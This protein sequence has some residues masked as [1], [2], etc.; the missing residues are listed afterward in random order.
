VFHIE[1]LTKMLRAIK[2]QDAAFACSFIE[3]ID[4][5]GNVTGIKRGW[6]SHLPSW[7]LKTAVQDS[8]SPQSFARNLLVSNFIST[9]S[10]MLFQRNVL[11]KVGGFRNLRFSH[12]WDFALRV[13]ADWPCTIV[14]E[15]LVRYRLHGSNTIKS[16]Q[17]WMLFE[18]CWVLVA[19]LH[20]FEKSLLSLAAQE[21]DDVCSAVDYLGRSIGAAGCERVMWLLQQFIAAQRKSGIEC[22]EEHLLE[23]GN[24]RSKFME[25][26]PSP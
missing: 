22:P 23:D 8:S 12:D 10:N 18:T 4:G 20:R 13:A 1:R 19:N 15:P 2:E 3:I 5:R 11:E 7:G 24:L 16:N 17:R 9:T 25:F 21:S 6:K 26:I 14:E